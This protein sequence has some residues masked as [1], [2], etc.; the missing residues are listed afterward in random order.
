MLLRIGH[1]QC[2]QRWRWQDEAPVVA[3]NTSAACPLL[4]HAGAVPTATAAHA[5]DPGHDLVPVAAA[6]LSRVLP[7][8]AACGG[9]DAGK[10]SQVVAIVTSSATS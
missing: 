2:R 6:P 5:A 8:P 10:G 4:I 9:D 3:A 7:A 1:C